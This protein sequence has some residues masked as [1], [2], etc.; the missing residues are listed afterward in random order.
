MAQLI[1]VSKDKLPRHLGYPLSHKALAEALEPVE[2]A[3]PVKLRFAKITIT[4]LGQANKL[5]ARLEDFGIF[6]ASFIRN[7]QCSFTVYGVAQT[8][9]SEIAAQ[10]QTQ[11]WTKLQSWLINSQTSI[12]AQLAVRHYL[13]IS[14]SSKGLAFSDEVAPVQWTVGLKENAPGDRMSKGE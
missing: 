6:H 9:L 8:Q 5:S 14:Y 12:E 2:L 3:S 7:G 10:L 13:T 1:T 11:F 4:E